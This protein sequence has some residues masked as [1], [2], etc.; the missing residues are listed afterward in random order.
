[1]KRKKA[2]SEVIKFDEKEI[3]KHIDGLVRQSV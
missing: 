1:M 2:I 3:Q